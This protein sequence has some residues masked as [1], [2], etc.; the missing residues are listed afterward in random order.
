MFCRV[1][2]A[3]ICGINAHKVYVE[4]DIC[5]GLPDFN[6]VGLPSSEIREAKERVIRA[7]TNSGFDFPSR[8]ITINLS[9]ANLRKIGSGFDLPI[10]IAILCAIGQIPQSSIKDTLIIGELSLDGKVNPI[11]GILPI[12]IMAQKEGIKNIILPEENAYEGAVIKGINIAP[13]KTLKNTIEILKTNSYPQNEYDDLEKILEKAYSDCSLDYIDVKGQEGAKR[14]TMI[15]ICGFHNLLYIGPPG[16]G[17]SMLSQRIPTILNR[18]S[19]EEC[20]EVSK[21]YSVAGLLD[22]KSLIL[23]RPFR[24]PHHSI[25]DAALVGGSSNP[26]PG[27][28]TLAN[29]GVLFLDEVAEFKKSTIEMLRQPLED[30]HI[31]IS[32]TNAQVDF[33]ADFMLV[34]AMNPCKCGYYPDR[35]FCKCTEADVNKYFGKIRGPI[36][37]RV[38]ITIG[39]KRLETD[40]FSTT[41]K[42]LSSKDMRLLIENAKEIQKERFKDLNIS[43]NSQMGQNEIRKF[44]TLDSKNQEL[45]NNAYEK[46]N[47]SARGYYKI[48]KVARTIADISESKEISKAHL[49]E[50]ISYRNQFV[51]R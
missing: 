26:K 51:D 43:F 17:K 37:D 27:E 48:L 33:P 8:R 12:A 39:T 47:M 44:C 10:A 34:M 25:S 18:L 38:D 7:I 46:F 23:N 20:L 36:L 50:A 13:V 28:I 24:S 9:P 42:G 5:G 4:A 15:A 29:K 1:L 19:I 21:I 22:G 30:K 2:C 6:I 40:D 11:K 3:D 32:R 35:N 49:L 31:L 14:A 41:T 16:S 45:L